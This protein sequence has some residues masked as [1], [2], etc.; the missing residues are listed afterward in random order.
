MSLDKKTIIETILC[1]EQL[2]GFDVKPDKFKKLNELKDVYLKLLGEITYE[3]SKE[4]ES[5][6]PSD[7]TMNFPNSI[8]N[9][10]SAKL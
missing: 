8:L 3:Q 5:I 4:I 7:P 2:S 1:I 9:F 10:G 6:L